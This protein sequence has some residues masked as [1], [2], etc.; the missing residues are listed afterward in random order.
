MMPYMRHRERERES[1]CVC[2]CVCL[3]ESKEARRDFL[4]PV[5]HVKS[6]GIASSSK[7]QVKS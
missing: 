5:W 3:R 7:Q 4:F 1:V 2:V 6:L